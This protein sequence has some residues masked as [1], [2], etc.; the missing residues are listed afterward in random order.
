MTTL[1]IY[2]LFYTENL[3]LNCIIYWIR[4]KNIFFTAFS[5]SYN[6][7]WCRVMGKIYCST[8]PSKQTSVCFIELWRLWWFQYKYINI[9]LWHL[10]KLRVLINYESFNTLWKHAEWEK[11][12][13]FISVFFFFFISQHRRNNT[14]HI[15]SAA[16][17]E[18][19]HHFREVK[20]QAYLC[21]RKVGLFTT[22]VCFLYSVILS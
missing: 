5:C 6:E 19:G 8:Q 18:M 21:L 3:L 7:T 15:L 2:Y 17:S 16:A 12:L 4:L 10:F 14:D 1:G 11:T 13:I 20:L 22:D 9:K